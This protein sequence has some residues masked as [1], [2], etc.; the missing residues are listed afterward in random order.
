MQNS[1]INN[2]ASFTI[3]KNSSANEV[4]HS[5]FSDQEPPSPKKL[6]STPHSCFSTYGYTATMATQLCSFGLTL[7]I[8]W[9][10]TPIGIGLALSGLLLFSVLAGLS[11]SQSQRADRAADLIHDISFFLLFTLITIPPFLISMQI[12][13]RSL[14]FF[15]WQAQILGREQKCAPDFHPWKFY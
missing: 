15:V 13:V 10:A 9:G 3:K 7:C 1:A 4:V 11:C 12:P 5:Q 8:T 2:D 6:Q 14:I